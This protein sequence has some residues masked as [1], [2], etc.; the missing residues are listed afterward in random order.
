VHLSKN[1][2]E[3]G[4][5]QPNSYNYNT[6]DICTKK[7]RITHVLANLFHFFNNLSSTYFPNKK[8]KI[9]FC[10]RRYNKCQPI[11][12]SYAYCQSKKVANYCEIRHRF[13]PCKKVPVKKSLHQ[14]ELFHVHSTHTNKC[15][16]IQTL[17]Q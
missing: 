8:R 17:T 7:H 1:W 13:F 12:F 5:Y 2:F 10:L 4:K 11:S 14:H 6:N 3:R 15:I 16:P 9:C